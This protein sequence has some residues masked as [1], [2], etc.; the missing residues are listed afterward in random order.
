LKLVEILNHNLKVRV[1]WL[2]MGTKSN[3]ER[4]LLRYKI[5]LN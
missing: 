2:S 5:I 4:V 3:T 1:N